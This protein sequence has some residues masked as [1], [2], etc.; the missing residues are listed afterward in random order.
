[1]LSFDRETGEIGK[2]HHPVGS[3]TDVSVY[4]GL[5][6]LGAKERH[7]IG[8]AYGGHQVERA[9]PVGGAIDRPGLEATKHQQAAKPLHESPWFRRSRIL[10]THRSSTS[11]KERENKTQHGTHS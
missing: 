11:Q 10:I 6:G 4:L 8:I 9:N 7:E 1:L 5:G 3:A 2:Q